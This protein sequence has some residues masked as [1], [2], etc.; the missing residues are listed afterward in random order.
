MQFPRNAK[1]FRGQ[2]DAAPFA[3]MLFLLVM[4]LWLSSKLALTPGV[5]IDLS[6]VADPVPGIQF[7][8]VVVAV[9]NSGNFYFEGRWISEEDLRLKLEQ[10]LAESPE[11][12]VLEVQADKAG[13]LET[14]V[15]LL[16]RARALRFKEA[17]IRVR[18]PILPLPSDP[19]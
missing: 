16:N 11:P 4:F 15:Q 3:G 2:L 18:P 13:K 5:R 1:I 6:E 14:T 19:E 9:D 10:R 17:L 7:P 12:L 8:T